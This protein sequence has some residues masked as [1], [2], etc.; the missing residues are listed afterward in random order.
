MIDQEKE[1]LRL[2]QQANAYIDDM[3][4]QP[5]Q[6]EQCLY[7]QELIQDAFFTVFNRHLTLDKIK[8]EL[9]NQNESK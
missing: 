7:A 1:L 4:L 9:K 2:I 8:D 6:K 3:D 5:Y